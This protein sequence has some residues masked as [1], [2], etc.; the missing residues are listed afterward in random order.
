[1]TTESQTTDDG[2]RPLV[3]PRDRQWARKIAA[4]LITHTTSVHNVNLIAEALAHARHF[5][6]D[7][8]EE[9]ADGK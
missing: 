5:G 4:K 2:T 7:D 3:E 6:W 8:D 1:M 9:C